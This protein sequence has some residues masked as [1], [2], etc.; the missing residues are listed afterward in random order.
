M[1][2]AVALFGYLKARSATELMRYVV[3]HTNSAVAVLDTNLHFI[4]VSARFIRDFDIEGQDVIGRH[5][6]D[7][8][9]DLP[10]KWREVHRKALQGE[11]LSADADP[12][13]RA[14][15]EVAYT[16]WQ[17]RPWHNSRGKIG[18]IIVYT[19]V[20]TDDILKETALKKLSTAVEQSPASVV[21]TDTEGTIEYVNP[22]FSDLTGYSREEAMGKNPNILRSGYQTDKIYQDLWN[23]ISSGKTW[24]GEL[25]NKKKDD[26]Y[27]WED[28]TIAPIVDEK[29]SIVNYIAIKEDI[30]KRKASEME[31]ERFKAIADESVFGM[32]LTTMD[33]RITYINRFFARVH[34]Y[35]PDELLG[36]SL[37]VFHT[38]EQLQQVG[39]LLSHL[40]QKGS[41]EPTEVWHL[42]KNGTTFPM[43]MTGLL[44]RD[45][46]GKPEYMAA[47][48]LDLT[49]YNQARQKVEES[50]LYHRSLLQTIPDIVFVMDKGGTFLDVKYSV[51]DRLLLPPSA[52]IG[53][54]ID[55]V[56]PPDIARIQL[57]AIESC[58][59]D[60]QV[61]SIEYAMDIDGETRYF[62]SRNIAFGDDRVIATV[63]DITQYKENLNRITHLLDVQEKQTTRLRNF[64]HIVSHNLRS[65]T[66]NMEGILDLMAMEEPELFE[67]SFIELIKTSS[68]SLHETI[69]NLNKVLDM[70]E[71]E[72]DEFS[73]VNLFETVERVI[74]SVSTL[75]ARSEVS[76]ENKVDPELI[77][78]VI[79]AYLDSIVLN[80]M[81]NGIMFHRS[82]AESFVKISSR[83]E[84]S[85]VAVVFED[86][87]LGVNLAA[88]GEHLFGMYKRFHSHVDSK[89]L[90]LF[91]VKN[92]VE[93]MGGRVEV[94]SEVGRGSI[95]TVYLPRAVKTDAEGAP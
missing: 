17:C 34:G 22:K 66:A 20:I 47:T 36:K 88:H 73:R 9:P 77:V 71:H 67:N 68:N 10:Q 26:S 45:E 42:H 94:E 23:T 46:F 51:T 15:G 53:R 83:E 58:F 70:S 87:G 63:R 2:A 11:V 21:I 48:A 44:M 24:R 85:E 52:F 37:N 79:P 33:G 65:N 86:N 62:N 55:A 31:A 5:H 60:A 38:E 90:G 95:F 72:T 32:A 74:G 89:G 49:R 61:T 59:R 82:D 7:V 29:G 69:D 39:P 40:A 41:F 57:G 35:E 27:Y 3:E 54:K 8:F 81:T 78:E 4:Y 64:T 28:A 80:M 43:L 75:A 6:Y 14:N 1:L 50:E 18:G 12:Y 25:L 93:A 91:I 30:S 19:A 56:L 16:R 84:A 13:I 76:L 92:Q